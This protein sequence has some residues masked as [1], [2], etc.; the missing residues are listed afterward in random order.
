MS[1]NKSNLSK[2]I[3]KLIFDE[4][5]ILSELSIKTYVS[6]VMKILEL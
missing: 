2:T 1:E 6:C 4:K 3:A 5:P